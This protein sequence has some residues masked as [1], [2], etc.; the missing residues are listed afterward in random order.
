MNSTPGRR[1]GTFL[2][3]LL[4]AVGP[5]GCGDSGEPV[6]DPSEAPLPVQVATAEALA[7][8]AFVAAAGVV[9]PVRRARMGTRQ[10]GTV[11]AVLVE[12]GDRVTAGQEILRVDSR[13]LE[14]SRAAA[15]KQRDTAQ[16]T[17]EQATRNR[18][19]FRR[20]YEQGLVAKIR[21]EE[22]ELRAERAE[23]ALGRAEAELAAIEVNL[24][25]ARLR[26]PFP[27]VVSE[28]LA[29]EGSFVAPGMPLV[30]FEDRA[31]LEVE[32]GVDQAS[33]TRL[34]AGDRLRVV[35]QGIDQLLEGRLQAVLP[36]LG[37]TGTGLRLRVLIEAPPAEMVPGM[38]AEVRVPS[39]RG[40]PGL[41]RIPANALLQRGQLNG[42]FVAEAG[43]DDTWRARLRWIA[44]EPAALDGD[45]L[46]VKRGL[47]AGE[48]VVLGSVTGEL[49]DGQLLEL[50]D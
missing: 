15:L 13:D 44:L 3:L 50:R 16:E 31:R 21:L 37:G 10:A 38:V 25:Y 24:D 26:A 28:I 46:H 39:R 29:E 5:Q 6:H 1:V 48:R 4:L 30:V 11:A 17:L 27:G 9:R 20:L 45:S 34:S 33:A 35:V 19:R 43:E 8:P 47:E 49:S 36:A 22:A 18:D 7:Q 32:A 40:P 12:A 23:S 2:V 42:V 41:V 14:A